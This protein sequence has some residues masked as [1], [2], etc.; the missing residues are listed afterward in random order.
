MPKAQPLSLAELLSLLPRVQATFELLVGKATSAAAPV[1]AASRAA[2][3]PRGRRRG[4]GDSAVQQKLLATLKASKGGLALG[5]LVKRVGAQR[6]AVKY[7]LRALREQKKVR[8][9]GDRK[10]A[11]WMAA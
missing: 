11:R 10:L 1:A 9:K 5:D 7:H 6:G 2:A 3:A 4:G 8:V